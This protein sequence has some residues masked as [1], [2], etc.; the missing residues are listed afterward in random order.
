MPA[1]MQ[2]IT[3]EEQS[4]SGLMTLI[5]SS[6]SHGFTTSITTSEPFTAWALSLVVLYPNAEK[7]ASRLLRTKEQLIAKDEKQKAAMVELRSQA[8]DAAQKEKEKNDAVEAATKALEKQRILDK[9][10]TSKLMPRWMEIKTEKTKTPDMFRSIEYNNPIKQRT[11][12]MMAFV[13]KDLNI[14]SLKTYDYNPT[15]SIFS[16]QDFRNNIYD[17]SNRN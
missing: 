13:D 1:A 8:K 6:T 11:K 16:Y 10:V 12:R 4:S 14:K 17:L 7:E 9:D 2:T 3:C 5:T 15:K